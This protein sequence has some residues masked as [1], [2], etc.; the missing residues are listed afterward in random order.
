MKTVKFICC[1][2]ASEN[3]TLE[4]ATKNAGMG[5]TFE[6]SAPGTPQQ[7]AVVER[8]FAT[9]MGRVQVMKN[10]AGFPKVKRS[11]LWTEAASTATKIDNML[12]YDNNMM[13]A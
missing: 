6:Y 13:H 7:N 1:N 10:M 5:I 11:Q 2:N 12:I 4:Q 8:A 3:T 9:L